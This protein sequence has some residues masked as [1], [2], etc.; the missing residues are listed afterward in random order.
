ML[1]LRIPPFPHIL[2]YLL[3][4]SKLFCNNELRNQKFD[5]IYAHWL[6]PAGIVGLILSKIYNCK[7]VGSIWGYDIQVLRDVKNYGI[8]GWN[9]IISRI[10]MEK[11][12][13]IIVNH[14]I[15][16]FLAKNMV[17]SKYYQK[18]VYIP[19]GI[20]DFSMEDIDEISADELRKKLGFPLD[21]LRGKKVVMYGPQLKPAYGIREFVK[22]AQI[23][24]KQI[25]DA[26]FIVTGDGELRDEVIK[27]IKENN[28]EDKVFL[29][30]KISHDSMINLYRLSTLVCDLAYPGTGTTTL[31][32]F[33]F[34]KP[35]IGIQ[36]PK[37]I[38]IHG[39]NGFTIKK[40][41]YQKLANYIVTIL[42]NEDYA[43]K[44]SL[45]ARKTFEEKYHID[46]RIKVL[47]KIF[48][49]LPKSNHL[50][51]MGFELR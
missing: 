27:F 40:G 9:R 22:A 31:E 13:L 30:G 21:K 16:R 8:S 43:K 6:F 10:V 1:K 12:D 46:K 50:N 34:G 20:P 7:I 14:K 19:P 42:Q 11:S 51:D 41:D 32:A 17:K 47:L 38:V 45:N 36:S 3:I 26:V 24:G 49:K 48:F 2:P 37:T 35:V 4:T 18:I 33:C 25:D 28:L 44:L 23:V 29:V 39:F 5:L 15:H